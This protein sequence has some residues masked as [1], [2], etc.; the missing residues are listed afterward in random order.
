M[1]CKVCG[2]TNPDD[3]RFCSCCGS[4]ISGKGESFSVYDADDPRLKSE[5]G[6]RDRVGYYS[7]D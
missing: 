6:D 3:A 5:E 2:K 1:N 7:E 4:S